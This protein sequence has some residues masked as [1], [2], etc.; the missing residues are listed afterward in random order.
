M[1]KPAKKGYVLRLDEKDFAAIKEAVVFYGEK[2]M[3]SFFLNSVLFRM[4][5]QNPQEK[6]ES[7]S[8]FA[9]ALK[10]AKKKLEA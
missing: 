3:H 7:L 2:S 4:Q 5:N 6:T 8:M 9:D 1:K 10:R